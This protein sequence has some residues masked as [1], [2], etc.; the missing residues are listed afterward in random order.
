MAWLPGWL[1]STSQ[2]ALGDRRADI[3]LSDLAPPRVGS[4][5]TLGMGRR[6]AG[7][8][9][10]A[11][12]WNQVR[13]MV[14]A[15]RRAGKTGKA[16]QEG[17][18]GRG[19]QGGQ[20]GNLVAGKPGKQPAMDTFNSCCAVR[21]QGLK[22][23]DHLGSMQCCLHAAKIM[24]RSRCSLSGLLAAWLAYW[25]PG[26]LGCPTARLPVLLPAWLPLVRSSS[27]FRP[28]SLAPLATPPHDAS[29]SFP[30][31]L[32]CLPSSVLYR[33]CS[34]AHSLTCCGGPFGSEAGSS[35]LSPPATCLL[36]T[37]AHSLFHPATWLRRCLTFRDGQRSGWPCRSDCWDASAASTTKLPVE[38]GPRLVQS[39]AFVAVIGAA[40]F[41]QPI[42]PCQV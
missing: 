40:V 8:K 36:R 1:A 21:V 2:E 23:E 33:A 7:G 17:K 41:T 14:G 29:P 16:G 34:C 24:E 20:P 5:P 22:Q 9:A 10:S 30:A 12:W 18:T 19:R 15:G 39:R 4:A 28:P 42:F 31:S 35:D 38:H 26:E 6:R 37:P 3:V 25:V 13:A 27:P 11:G 32:P